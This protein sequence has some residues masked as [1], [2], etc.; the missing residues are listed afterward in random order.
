MHNTSIIVQERAGTALLKKKKTS[1]LFLVIL[2]HHYGHVSQSIVTTSHRET[3]T[4]E[5]IDAPNYLLPLS[6]FRHH[7]QFHHQLTK[8]LIYMRSCTLL[9]QFPF[10]ARNFRFTFWRKKEKKREEFNRHI[11]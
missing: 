1:L 11:K 10:V 9:F 5:S 2:Y 6:L 4:P 8:S 3:V 7:Y